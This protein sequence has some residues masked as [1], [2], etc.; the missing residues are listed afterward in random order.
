MKTEPATFFCPNC[1]E[2]F[3]ESYCANC[4]EKRLT[5]KDFSVK[6]LLSEVFTDFDLLNNKLFKTLKLLV[7]NP[8][9]YFGDYLNGKRK[10]YLKPIQLFLIANALYFFIGAFNSFMTPLE[11]QQFQQPYSP[12]VEQQIESVINE[13]RLTESAFE[14][15]FNRKTT[16][17]SKSILIVFVVIHSI[18]AYFFFLRRKVPLISLFQFSLILMSFFLLVLFIT[19]PAILFQVIE[20]FDLD[21]N[22]LSDANYTLFLL[23]AMTAYTYFLV[24]PL[25]REPKVISIAKAFGLTLSL[26]IVT[27]IYRLVLLQLT[28]FLM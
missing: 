8:G 7:F 22:L 13:S 10:P 1:G 6:A 16:S 14:E 26:L 21:P 27:Y 25:V 15:T 9:I 3:E 11:A 5:E 2:L 12:L 24:R 20:F 19:L 28:L 4:G 17:L 23:L 18:G